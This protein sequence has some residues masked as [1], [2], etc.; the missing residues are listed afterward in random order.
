MTTTTKDQQAG[1]VGAS[2]GWRMEKV[3]IFNNSTCNDA[4]ENPSKTRIYK[5][6][7]ISRS[8]LK[9]GSIL[10]NERNYWNRNSHSNLFVSH[11]RLRCCM[12]PISKGKYEFIKI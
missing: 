2:V 7:R 11:E 4:N 5:V 1:S 9:F 12:K 8:H 10:E 3:K 6:D